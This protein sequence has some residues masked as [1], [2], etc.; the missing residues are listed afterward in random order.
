MFTHQAVL[1]ALK[2]LRPWQPSEVLTWEA[3]FPAADPA[4]QLKRH[5][6]ADLVVDIGHWFD[7]KGAATEVHVT[8]YRDFLYNHPGTSIADITERVESYHRW[9]PDEVERAS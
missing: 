7:Q 8:Q 2:L 3:A 6:V 5:D 1:A 9:T 4:R